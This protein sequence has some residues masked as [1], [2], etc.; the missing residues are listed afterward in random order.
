MPVLIFET[1]TDL[2]VLQYA[3]ARQS[4]TENIRTW[5]V[6]G[7]AHSDTYSL[8]YPNGLPRQAS[9]GAIIGCENLIND[10]PQHETLQAAFHQLN[11][12]IATG[13]APNSSPRILL[14]DSQELIIARDD[15]GIALGGVRTHQ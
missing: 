4:D 7:A 8:A 1:E 2:N 5:E 9:L 12:W 11:N 10:G 15:M 14:E 3:N 13:D 6:A